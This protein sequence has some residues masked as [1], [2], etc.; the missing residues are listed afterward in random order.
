MVWEVKGVTIGPIVIANG[1]T[2][3]PIP[4]PPP[5]PNILFMEIQSIVQRNCVSVV[6]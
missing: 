2:K 3:G 6:L 5:T 4:P 1:P